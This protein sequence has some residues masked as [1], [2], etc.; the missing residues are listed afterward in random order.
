MPTS[1]LHQAEKE[2]IISNARAEVSKEVASTKAKIDTD[3]AAAQ[4]KAK[5]D[6]DTQIA[7]ALAKLDAA[8]AESGKVS[9]HV[10]LKDILSK[11][12]DRFVHLPVS[13]CHVHRKRQY[14]NVC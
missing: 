4:A 13:D 10:M 11:K 3:I 5:A 6:V 9:T 8:K 12:N 2:S 7:A 14:V 1:D